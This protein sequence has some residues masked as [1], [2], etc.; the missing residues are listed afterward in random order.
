MERTNINLLPAFAF[1][2]SLPGKIL[3]W[4]INV[5][6]YIVIGTEFI[7]IIAFL[8]RLKLDKDLADLHD[9]IKEKQATIISLSNLEKN[10]RFLQ[11]RLGIIKKIQGQQTL[12][13]KLLETFSTITPSD[14]YFKSFSL[15]G[16]SLKIE[17]VALSDASLAM[18]LSNL[19]KDNEFEN[20]NLSELSTA[21]S[22]NPEISFTLRLAL[23]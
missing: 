3:A 17:A 14:I 1:Q 23:K 7:V 4:A 13:S 6:R 9:A 21:G 20:I 8:F 11:D 10:V 2:K 18:F 15:S 22:A 16:K 5:G 19:Q 12:T